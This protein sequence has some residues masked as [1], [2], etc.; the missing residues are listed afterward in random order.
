MCSSVHFSD[1]FAVNQLVYAIKGGFDLI[2]NNLS[3]LV[4]LIQAGV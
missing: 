1:K 3:V 4:F 2:I